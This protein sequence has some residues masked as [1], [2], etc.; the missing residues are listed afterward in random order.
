MSL[1]NAAVT[2]LWEELKALGPSFIIDKGHDFGSER[3]G[4]KDKPAGFNTRGNTKAGVK[5]LSRFC[6]LLC[7]AFVS[8]FPPDSDTGEIVWADQKIIYYTTPVYALLWSAAK[9]HSIDPFFDNTEAVY[10][11]KYPIRAGLCRGARSYP[12]KDNFFKRD[13]PAKDMKKAALTTSLTG[14]PCKVDTSWGAGEHGVTQNNTRQ[15]EFLVGS[16]NEMKT[17]AGPNTK[18]IIGGIWRGQKVSIPKDKIVIS[19]S[20]V[21]KQKQL[22]SN[23]L[24]N[25]ELKAGTSS[26]LDAANSTKGEQKVYG[27]RYNMP[28][29]AARRDNNKFYINVNVSNNNGSG[30]L[31]Q[32]NPY[33][34]LVF[35]LC[36]KQGTGDWTREDDREYT[37]N[38][39]ESVKLF[40]G[41]VSLLGCLINTLVNRNS[42]SP[43]SDEQYQWDNVKTIINSMTNPINPVQRLIKQEQILANLI[44]IAKIYADTI[45]SYN[46]D[47]GDDEKITQ[48]TNRVKFV[49]AFIMQIKTMGDFSSLKDCQWFEE[50]ENNPNNPCFILTKD[51]FLRK[52]VNP[53]YKGYRGKLIGDKNLK[54]SPPYFN[55][56]AFTIRRRAEPQVGGQPP[57]NIDD[58]NSKLND[59]KGGVC[60][61][62]FAEAGGLYDTPNDFCS[63]EY[64]QMKNIDAA[65]A[66]MNVPNIYRNIQ[67]F[68]SGQQQIFSVNADFTRAYVDGNFRLHDELFGG[69]FSFS[70][71]N[72]L[73][74][75][76]HINLRTSI[77]G[78]E[79]GD[80]VYK[81]NLNYPNDYY[82]NRASAD[83]L[84]TSTEDNINDINYLF[85]RAWQFREYALK[86]CREYFPAAELSAG[87]LGRVENPCVYPVGVLLDE[88]DKKKLWFK[89]YF[90]SLSHQ[91]PIYPPGSPSAPG[92]PERRRPAAS[93]AASPSTPAQFRRRSRSSGRKKKRGGNGKKKT[94]RK[95]KRKKKTKR[96]KRRKR[97]KKTKKKR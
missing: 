76:N 97:K 11:K 66:A 15:I 75:Q 93:A 96:K 84:R 24:S 53:F 27:I 10:L 38:I 43:A 32:A 77:G 48:I 44:R 89:D 12:F 86:Q 92:S 40:P 36:R 6:K 78:G 7:S 1:N 55:D 73:S 14:N 74:L 83:L 80:I 57:I 35:S 16:K 33:Y 65:I 22:I 9:S 72:T 45:Y 41:E 90:E 59:T 30:G 63:F 68:F 26:F 64:G 87:R 28:F 95:I 69:F 39:Q 58:L 88:I 17:M 62:V 18:S 51:T 70:D 23:L 82:L 50:D 37:L 71:S 13:G 34:T 79:L 81:F 19:D 20:P 29:L 94:K 47:D 49:F 52:I 4:K 42:E 60:E 3:T 8:D 54:T 2:R 5:F 91:F 21:K 67:H 85:L 56:K 31:F 46:D 61:R 25:S